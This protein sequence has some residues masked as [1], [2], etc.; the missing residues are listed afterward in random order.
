MIS[1]FIIDEQAQKAAEILKDARHIVVLAG[2]G[3]SQISGH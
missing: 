3:L 1:D 2:A